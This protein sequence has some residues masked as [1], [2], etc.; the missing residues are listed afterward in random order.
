MRAGKDFVFAGMLIR[1]SEIGCPCR[2]SATVRNISFALTTEQIRN[3]TK[4]VTR[5]L[6]WKDL[7]PGTPLQPVVKGM[8]LKKG[9][10]VEKIGGPIRVVNVSRSPL[11]SI[12]P[13]DV[14]REGFPQMT[15]REFVT[16]FKK[17]H[18]GCRVATEVTRIEFEYCDDEAHDAAKGRP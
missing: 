4:T 7:K 5:R 16:M 11:N 9:E 13:Q 15:V 17:S 12:S 14:H 8:G 6:G 2:E 10:T 1:P 18:R 3:R